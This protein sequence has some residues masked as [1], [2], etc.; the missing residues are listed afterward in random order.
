M[1]FSARFSGI[2]HSLIRFCSLCSLAACMSRERLPKVSPGMF[3]GA[4][5]AVVT[6]EVQMLFWTHLTDVFVPETDT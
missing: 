6:S 5:V 1:E 3:A 4:V 2:T